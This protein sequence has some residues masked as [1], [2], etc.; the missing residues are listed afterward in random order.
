[1][2]N[3]GMFKVML[4]IVTGLF[5]TNGIA[6]AKDQ[7]NIPQAVVSSLNNKYPN[8]IIRKW[9]VQDNAYTAKTIVNGHKYFATFDKSGNWVSTVSNVNW[10]YKMPEVINSAYQKSPYN[11]WSVYFAKKVEK[12]S[13]EFYQLLVD[14]VNLHVGIN[15]Q[16][17]YTQDKMLE[18]K[19][20]GMLTGI[21]DITFDPGP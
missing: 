19:A 4:V 17:V 1:M 18:F 13:G 3:S 6:Q 2:K 15:H 11:N 20:D 7:S 12:P 16:L 8:A 10:A 5:I 9:E 21:K 14:D